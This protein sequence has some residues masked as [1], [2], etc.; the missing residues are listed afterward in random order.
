MA[1]VTIVIDATGNPNLPGPTILP[2]D[3]IAFQN[4]ADPPSVSINF[5][6]ENGPVFQNI[7][8]LGVSQTSQAQSPLLNNITTDYNVVNDGT[9]ATTGPF[10]I[11]VGTNPQVV[12]DPL[13]V[14]I[15]N[16]DP[17]EATVS[18]P[19]N[20]WLQFDI[21]GTDPYTFNWTPTGVFPNGSFGPGLVGPWQSKTGN[22][23]SVAKYNL[24][25]FDGTGGSGTV[26]IRS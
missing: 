22:Q 18:I 23:N 14:S 1:K 16:G 2:S 8:K 26:K 20:G 13:L 24:Q 10:C 25:K 15:V 9:G 12:P 11:A 4:S 3:T 19:L 21:Q 6:C 17:Q 5:V 7:S